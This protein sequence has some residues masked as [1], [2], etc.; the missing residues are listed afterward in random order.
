MYN[1]PPVFV[2]VDT[3]ALRRNIENA[4]LL[5]LAI[6]GGLNAIV[7]LEHRDFSMLDEEGLKDTVAAFE[8][9]I[10]VGYSLPNV[11]EA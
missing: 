4:A 2:G 8:R 7:M 3:D 11:A 9:V 5:S 6:A 1:L 10:A